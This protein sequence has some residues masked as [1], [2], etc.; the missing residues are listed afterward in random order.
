MHQ[1]RSLVGAGATVLTIV[2]GIATLAVHAQPKRTDADDLRAAYETYRS[3]QQFV[4]VRLAQVAV[5][6]ADEHQRAGDRHCRRRSR[7][8]SPDLRR[9][10][11]ERCMAHR[12]QRVDLAAVLRELC[13]PRALAISPWRPRT[14][15]SSG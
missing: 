13:R 5:A 3:M 4:P 14:P 1:G 11:D 2:A 10:C 7:R 12:R 15:T 9:L 6:R 8:G